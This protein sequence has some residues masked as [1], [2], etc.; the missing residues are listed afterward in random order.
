MRSSVVLFVAWTMVLSVAAHATSYNSKLYGVYQTSAAGVTTLYIVPK[1]SVSIL[2]SATGLVTPIVFM[3]KVPGV[4]IIVNTDGSLGALASTSYN[5]NTISTIGAQLSTYHLYSADFTGDGQ[6]DLLLQGSGTN[7]SFVLTSSA[8]S[9]AATVSYNFGAALDSTT[10]QLTITDIDGNGIAD[11]Q[12]VDAQNHLRAYISS[13]SGPAFS[14]VDASAT[15]FATTGQRAAD[16]LVANMNTADKTWGSEPNLKYPM[17]AEVALALASWNKRSYEYYAALTWLG[18]HNPNSVDFAAKR[19]LALQSGGQSISQDVNY[20]TAAQAANLPTPGNGGAGLSPPYQGS[21][22]D[23]AWLLQAYNKA[24]ISANVSAATTYLKNTQLTSSDKGWVIGQETNSDP[25]TTAEVLI[26]L[27]PYRATDTSLVTPIANGL[28]TLNA[29]VTPSST[30]L[31]KALAALAERRDNGNSLQATTLLVSLISTQGSDGSWGGDVLATAMALRALASGA[32][33]DAPGLQ[34]PVTIPDSNLRAAINTALSRNA[35]DTLNQGELAQL[36]SLS[37]AG[38]NVSNLTG[39][40]YAS[41]LSYLDASNNNI[42]SWTPVDNLAQHPTTIR[43]GN[44]GYPTAGYDTPTLPQ[45][46]A[47]LLGALLMWMSARNSS[48]VPLRRRWI[49]LS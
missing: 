46:G 43:D 34:T 40:E 48:G 47:I 13:S 30:P 45:W 44:P 29:A 27:I 25:I 18:N 39:L 24:G 7:P 21:A 32:G 19:V 2:P 28:A 5:A 15:Q 37:I 38:Q 23:T 26:A 6:R 14:V 9:G 12:T 16:W 22:L 49:K 20:L 42:T 41:N 33:R 1:R 11:I 3:P 4:Q 35:L 8:T 36:T 31:K 17:T 10:Q